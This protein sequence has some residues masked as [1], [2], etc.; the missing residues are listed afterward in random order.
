MFQGP[1]GERSL[2]SQLLLLK[3]ACEGKRWRHRLHR[4]SLCSS[5]SVAQGADCSVSWCFMWIQLLKDLMSWEQ[6][7][8]DAAA[9]PVHEDSWLEISK[10]WMYFVLRM[11]QNLPASCIGWLNDNIDNMMLQLFTVP[12]KLDLIDFISARTQHLLPVCVYFNGA[13]WTLME[14]SVTT[15][16]SWGNRYNEW[17]APGNWWVLKGYIDVGLVFKYPNM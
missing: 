15:G 2:T 5:G 12:V 1:S 16:H 11:L 6:I 10:G 17:V 13:Q 4:L 9:T 3:M 7:L 8:M 14:S